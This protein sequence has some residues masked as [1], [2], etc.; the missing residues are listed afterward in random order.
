M[1]NICAPASF[2]KGIKGHANMYLFYFLFLEER[3]FNKLQIVSEKCKQ[4]NVKKSNH[5]L[6]LKIHTAIIRAIC[7]AVGYLSTLLGGP[8]GMPVPCDAG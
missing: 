2:P 6:T 1:F 7:Q 5:I 8:K 4:I 3:S